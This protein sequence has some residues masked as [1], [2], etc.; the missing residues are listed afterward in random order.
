MTLY[1]TNYH[2]EDRDYCKTAQQLTRDKQQ[3]YGQGHSAAQCPDFVI[4]A[5]VKIAE[6]A[7]DFDEF[8][9]Y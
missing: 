9:I 5:R 3:I 4:I 6:P 1:C 8:I 7:I 2:C